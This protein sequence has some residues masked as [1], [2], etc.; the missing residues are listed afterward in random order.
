MHFSWG[1]NEVNEV[2][3]TIKGLFPSFTSPLHV[4]SLQTMRGVYDGAGY[5]SDYSYTNSLLLKII[6][7]N[8]KI[9]NHY[10]FLW[11]F[12]LRSQLNLNG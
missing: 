10:S 1:S 5:K 9:N 12:L 7:Q 4:V 3:F 8:M 11:F 6:H 2:I